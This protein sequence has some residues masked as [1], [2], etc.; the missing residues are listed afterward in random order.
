MDVSSSIIKQMPVSIEAEQAVLGAVIINPECFDKVVGELSAEDFYLEDHKKLYNAIVSM[1]TQNKTIDAITLVNALTEQGGRDKESSIQYIS[2][3]A[4]SVPSVANLSE[5][6]KIVKDKSLLR[7]LIETCDDINKDAFNGDGSAR[8][9]LDSAEQRIFDLSNGNTE[10]KG[11]RHIRDILQNVYA[12]LEV[13]SVTKGAVTGAKTGFSGLDKRLVQMGKGDLVIVGARPGMGKTSFAMNI[14]T[15][16]AKSSRKAVCIFSLEMSGEQL[17][18]RILSSEALVD[19]YSL[20]TGHLEKEDWDNLAQVATSLS[21]CEIYIDDTSAITTADM[22]AKLRRIKNLG[23][24]VI[25]SISGY[26][27]RNLRSTSY[28]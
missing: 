3:L 26:S 13:L 15:N 9:I 4:E 11:F 5:Y 27:I 16:V 6:V 21:G 8:T 18:T 23:L 14:A 7:K 12:D 24:V 17:V 22:R 20:R 2:L 10:S 1:Y 19:S 28:G 25:D